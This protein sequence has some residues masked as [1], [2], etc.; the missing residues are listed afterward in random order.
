MQAEASLLLRG[1]TIIAFDGTDH[2]LLDGGVV[3]LAGDRILHVGRAWDCRAARDI[4]T[5]GRLVI[6]GQI[7]THAHIGTHAGPRL[8]IDGGRRDLVRS[9]LLHF[10]PARREGGPGFGA[11]AD[12]RA[13]L[14]CG[15]ATLLRHGVTT[16]RAFAPGG[17]DG[18]ATMLEVA[19]RMGIRLVR[20][21]IVTGGRYWREAD[22]RVTRE[23]DEALGFQLLEAAQRF[24]A[25]LPEGGLVSG[26]ITLDEYHASTQALRQ[27]AK[28]AARAAGVPFTLHVIEQHREVFET[29]MQ[30]GRTPVQLLAD[31]GVLDPGTIL[32]HCIDHAGHSLVG[33][34]MADDVALMGQA[35]VAVAHSPVAFSRRGVALE[36]FDRFRRAG[37][38]MALRT[39]AYPL[40]MLAE[41]RMASLMG[42]VVEKN[43]EAA[44]GRSEAIP[45]RWCCAWPAARCSPRCRRPASAPSSAAPGRRCPG[46]PSIAWPSRSRA[47]RAAPVALAPVLRLV[48]V[49]ADRE[50]PG[51][52]HRR[53]LLGT[54]TLLAAA[55][56]LA[57]AP[58]WPARPVRVLIGYGPGGLGDVT[59]RIVT[60]KL[61][62]K[63]GRPF[64]IEN[65]PGAGGILAS[66]MLM[67]APADGY[68]LMMAATGNVAMTPALFRSVPFDV[69]QDFAPACLTCLF[70]FAIVVRGDS[71]IRGVADLVALAKR[72]P[73]AL[74]FGTVSV[75]SA[76]YVGT[77]LF[78]S[79]AGVEAV[80]VPFRTTGE[81]I[82]ALHSGNVEVAIEASASL[83]EQFASGQLRPLA[84]TTP[85]R[86]PL[87]PGVPT[88][89]EV[90]LPEYELTSWNGLVARTGTPQ[91]ILD[92]LNAEMNAVLRLPEVVARFRGLGVEPGGGTP[93][94]FGELIR[95]DL[96]KWASA[97]A[98][99]RIER[100]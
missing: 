87:L 62:E 25:A 39:D 75:G 63:L 27:A 26:T 95:R 31:E 3:A 17:D 36:S 21:P 15:F 76:Q 9:G 28:A 43:D 52:M 61:A 94:D 35:G 24:I 89:R 42:K 64:I 99:A 37:V 73:G 50:G 83:L 1:G 6:P 7:S 74:N 51:T 16:V 57:Q 85:S 60:E 44:L 55:P 54:A 2:R 81:V 71:P 41:R 84:L 40:D 34:P 77:E 8:L 66:Q 19:A 38:T 90:G 46:S 72:Q 49:Q 65:R 59:T 68:T 58:A 18:G 10:L 14:R 69:V 4:D 100:Q 79:L 98:V 47:D 45:P 91:P 48:A 78:K 53:T 12:A 32:A 23:L 20:S 33:Y 93:A 30:T 67:Q 82:A 70:G 96:A 22:G 56:A 29:M 80:T 13:S 11:K 86:S 88:A 97:I 92:L 5:G